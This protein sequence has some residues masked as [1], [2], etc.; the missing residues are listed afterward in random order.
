ME[1]LEKENLQTKF[2]TGTSIWEFEKSNKHAIIFILAL[3]LLTVVNVIISKCEFAKQ[4]EENQFFY[5]FSTMAQVLAGMIALTIAAY[6]FF[7]QYLLRFSENNPDFS[8]VIND[9]KIKNFRLI[10]YASIIS[11]IAVILCIFG[12]LYVPNNDKSARINTLILLQTVTFFA[13]GVFMIV[14]V[15]TSLLNEQKMVRQITRKKKNIDKELNVVTKFMESGDVRIFLDYYV[16]LE[17]LLS[18]IAERIDSTPSMNRNRYN[19]RIDISTSLYVLALDGIIY[20]FNI[21]KIEKVKEYRNGIVHGSDK[22]ISIE[23]QKYLIGVYEKIF[24][25]ADTVKEGNQINVDIEKLRSHAGSLN[26][27]LEALARRYFNI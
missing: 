17:E 3:L 11:G 20:P 27:E 12:L 14:I 10:V 23:M 9:Y 24:S 22:T 7:C 19:N 8:D 18:T 26:V 4:I 15:G 2:V 21:M 5:S 13:F 25:A 1:R 16:R 6:S